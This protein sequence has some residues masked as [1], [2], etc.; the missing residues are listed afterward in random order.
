M[1][2]ATATTK[3]LSKNMIGL[4]RKK[5]RAARSTCGAHLST[6]SCGTLHINTPLRFWWQHEHTIE[7]LLLFV[8][9]LKPLSPIYLFYYDIK[10]VEKSRKIKIIIIFLHTHI[11]KASLNNRRVYKF[12]KLSNY[13]K[14]S[15]VLLIKMLLKRSVLILGIMKEWPLFRK[16][17]SLPSWR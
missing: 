6:D 12:L 1:T 9:T 2:T 15:K 8:F 13:L 4:M 5:K 3:P 17:L 7:N 10:E 16:T 14:L 11:W